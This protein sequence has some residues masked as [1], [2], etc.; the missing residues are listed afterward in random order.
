VLLP[1]AHVLGE[2]AAQ[3]PHNRT[4]CGGTDDG[5]FDQSGS[6]FTIAPRISVVSSPSNAR[7]PASISSSTQPNAQ[8]SVRRSTALPFACS[9]DM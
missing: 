8:M 6:V 1:L 2:T 9:G 5:S 3:Q 7:E 4:T